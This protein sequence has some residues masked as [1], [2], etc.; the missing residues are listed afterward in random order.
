MSVMPKSFVFD[1]ETPGD[2]CR[3]KMGRSCYKGKILAIGT[4]VETNR[5]T[6]NILLNTY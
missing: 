1:G 3:V 2:E 5:Y 4:Y 6:I